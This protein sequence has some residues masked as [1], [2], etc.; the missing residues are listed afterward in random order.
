MPS[1]RRFPFALVVVAGLLA[2]CA[3]GTSDPAGSGPASSFAVPDVHGIALDPA[4]AGVLYVATHTGLLKLEEDARWSAV[5]TARD[6]YMGFSMHP[7]NASIVWASGHPARG[8]NLGVI[9]SKDGGA[10]WRFL[11]LEGVDFHAMAVSPADPARL[12]GFWRGQVLRSDDAG[13]S[14]APV[15]P[16]SVTGF[17]PHPTQRDVVFAATVKDVQRSD[18]AGVSWTR[19]SAHPAISVAVDPNAPD[20]LY[21]GSTLGAHKSLDAGRT[22]APM[23]LPEGATIGHFAT[24]AATS[25]LVYAASFQVGIYKSTDSGA[26]WTTVRAPSR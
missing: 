13:A 3:S 17:A 15:G 10:S 5:G 23:P 7:R 2:G 25:G 24:H 16:L 19:V 20:V 4:D 1:V 18:D 14:W 26:T 22:W 8:G 21:A 9:Q 6:D 11:A 12:Y